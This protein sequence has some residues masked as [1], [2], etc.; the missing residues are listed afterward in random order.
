MTKRNWIS[1]FP[2]II[3]LV[4][5]A[6]ASGW[7]IE[8]IYIKD[9]AL[10]A[11]NFRSFDLVLLVLI[12]PLSIVMLILAYTGRSWA[13]VFVLGII[14]YLAFTYGIN[15]FSCHQNHLFLIYI[16][17]LGLCVVSI[18]RG[19]PDIAQ[20][21]DTSSKTV[22][23]RVLSITILFIALAG[24]V[25]WLSD[26]IGALFNGESTQNLIEKNIPV[27]VAQVLDMAFMLPFAIFG[28]IKLLKYHSEGL[29]ISAV[30]LVFFM[31]I[32]MSVVTMEIRLSRITGSEMDFAKVYSYGFIT[33]LSLV[34]TFFTYRYVSRRVG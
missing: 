13:R 29:V 25:Y 33:V 2:I 16:A 6:A 9:S 14:M 8:E 12:T 1:I 11:V 28:A 32:G 7:F 15:V 21:I 34:V 4:I 5:A 10:M 26:A 19:F 3:V 22:L 31:L 17:L 23:M 18:A 27:N 30:M 24:Y 20:I